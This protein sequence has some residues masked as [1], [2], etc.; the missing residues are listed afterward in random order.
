[1][2][3]AA[4]RTPTPARKEVS[5]IETALFSSVPVAAADEVVAVPVE[6]AVDSVEVPVVVPVAVDVVAPVVVKVEAEMEMEEVAST[7]L[8]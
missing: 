7:S 8:A 4:T 3:N 6:S 1:M 5:F 2:K